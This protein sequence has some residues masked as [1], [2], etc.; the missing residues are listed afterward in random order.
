M[1]RPRSR[2]VEGPTLLDHAARRGAFGGPE[3]PLADR[4]RPRSLDEIVGQAPLLARGKP[5]REAINK[6]EKDLNATIRAN[7]TEVAVFTKQVEKIEKTRAELNTMRTVML[8]RIR[9]VLSD[10]QHRKVQ[11]MMER[12]ESERRR[13]DD[14]RH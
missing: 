9:R 10:E 12:R 14:R 13:Q 1:T 4:M 3:A 8:Y 7:T 6:M 11:A 5:L 2:Q